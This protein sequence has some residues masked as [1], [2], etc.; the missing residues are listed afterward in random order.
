MQWLILPD[1]PQ[2]DL[3][4][5]APANQFPQATSLHMN[6][7]DP[8]FMLAPDL[9]HCQGR[10]HALIE[11]ADGAITVAADEDVAGDLIGGEGGDARAGAGGDVLVYFLVWCQ[12]LVGGDLHWCRFR[13]RRS[14]LELPLR[15]LLQE[16]YLGLAANLRLGRRSCC[17]GL[18]RS[19]LGKQIPVLPLFLIR[20]F[21]RL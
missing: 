2:L 3:S 11:D 20:N 6:V 21:E 16:A 15:R 4:I 14:R 1:I 19:E 13:W 9:D 12:G 17:L 8:L 5:P 18:G 7:R 10:L